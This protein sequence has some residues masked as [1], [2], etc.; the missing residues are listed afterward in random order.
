VECKVAACWPRKKVSSHSA[1]KHA[2]K[3]E[4]FCRELDLKYVRYMNYCC[5]VY[6]YQHGRLWKTLGWTGKLNADII[7]PNYGII[8]KN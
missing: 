6:L 8:F 4:K 1:N 2:S 3:S 5:F 7:F